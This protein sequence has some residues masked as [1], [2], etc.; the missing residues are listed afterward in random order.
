MTQPKPKCKA[1]GCDRRVERSSGYCQ[2]HD[3]RWRKYGDPMMVRTASNID[4]KRYGRL[5]V[6]KETGRRHE[7]RDYLCRCDCGNETVVTRS[8]LICE[9]TKSCGCLRGDANRHNAEMRPGHRQTGTP[10]YITWQAMRNRCYN[11]NADQWNR[12]GGRGVAVC[13][14]WRKSFDN[15]L[16]DMGER[17]EGKTLDRIDSDGNYEPDNCRWATPT[18]QSRNRASSKLTLEKAEA[19]RRDRKR[20]VTRAT[21]VARYK[22]SHATIAEVETGEIWRSA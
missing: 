5:V 16:A 15:F 17:P 1:P 19:I 14:R 22:V 11:P 12:Y 10:T 18:E 3:Y 7:K 6:L 20:G 2:K 9:R 8:N 13:D 21:L 4:G